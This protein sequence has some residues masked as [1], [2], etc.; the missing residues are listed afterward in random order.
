MNIRKLYKRKSCKGKTLEI[1]A[2]LQ[3]FTDMKKIGL[4]LQPL[5]QLQFELFQLEKLLAS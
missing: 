1:K 5:E 3:A 2:M 4:V